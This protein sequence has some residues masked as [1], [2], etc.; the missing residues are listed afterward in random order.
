MDSATVIINTKHYE[1]SS[2]KNASR[3]LEGFASIVKGL[4]LRIIFALNPIDL[5]LAGSF[6]ELEIYSQ[7]VYPIGFGPFTGKF[8][9][10]SVM[11]MGVKGSIINHSENRMQLDSITAT[12]KH[13]REMRF[14]LVICAGNARE[15]IRISRL[16]PEFV[17][18]EPP[19]LIGG[20]ISVST[21]KPEIISE[22]VKGCSEWKTNVLVGAGVKTHSDME[23]SL[24]LGAKGVLIS[25]GIVLAEDPYR[26][27]YQLLGK[28][29]G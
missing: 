28:E 12:V 3:F 6:P 29:S 13:S 18:Y 25:S 11:E 21:A 15:A 24:S 14:N 7:T 27:L 20:N 19:E 23:K 26:S 5:H 1:R 4:D 10:D 8:S 16:Q 17:A 9:I 22:V 2:G